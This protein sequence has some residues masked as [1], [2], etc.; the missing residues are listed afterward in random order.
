[1]RNSS[2]SKRPLY[3]TTVSKIRSMRCES[4]RW[5][6]ASTTSCC[7]GSLQDNAVHIG[8]IPLELQPNQDAGEGFDDVGFKELAA[9]RTRDEVG[10]GKHGEHEG[11]DEERE[12]DW[13]SSLREVPQ[14][15]A[16]ER[17]H[18]AGGF[19][20]VVKDRE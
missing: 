11:G 9:Q 19:G 7:M 16:R 10:R 17:N 6:S 2:T 13:R 20:G 8:Q 14:G 3:S 18:V 12:I 4:I 15:D 5:P 1:M